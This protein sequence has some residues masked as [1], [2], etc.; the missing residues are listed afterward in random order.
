MACAGAAPTPTITAAAAAVIATPVIRRRLMRTRFM[1]NSFVRLAGGGVIGVREHNALDA[2]GRTS[3]QSPVR[4][5]GYR[6]SG[7][8]SDRELTDGYLGDR[9]AYK[10]PSPIRGS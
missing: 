5:S 3:G 2:P 9:F 8:P 6:G 4:H 7:Q 1:E 10:R